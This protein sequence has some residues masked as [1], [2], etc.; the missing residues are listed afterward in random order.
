MC[1]LRPLRYPLPPTIQNYRPSPEESAR[2]HHDLHCRTWEYD[3]VNPFQHA[4]CGLPRFH[5]ELCERTMI[6][7]DGAA[8]DGRGRDLVV[9][10]LPNGPMPQPRHI[11]LVGRAGPAFPLLSTSI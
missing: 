10:P 9:S 2:L 8:P 1:W 11:L 3:T 4:Q 6:H 7:G 5:S